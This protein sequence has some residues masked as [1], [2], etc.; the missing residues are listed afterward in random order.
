MKLSIPG[1]FGFMAVAIVAVVLTPALYAVQPAPATQ[2]DG[3]LRGRQ[4]AN[5]RGKDLEGGGSRQN[6][7]RLADAGSV[8]PPPCPPSNHDSGE[9][10]DGVV[11]IEPIPGIDRLCPGS[12][13]SGNSGVRGVKGDTDGA[14]PRTKID[15]D[16]YIRR[17]SIFPVVTKEGIRVRALPETPDKRC[18]IICQGRVNIVSESP[19]FGVIDVEADEVTITR[20]CERKKNTARAADGATWVDDDDLPME[21][22]FKGNV[23]LLH[24]RDGGGGG[25]DER[26][27]IRGAELDYVFVT[28]RLTAIDATVLILRSNVPSTL[29]ASRIELSGFLT[30]QPARSPAPSGDRAPHA[31]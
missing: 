1:G 15:L 20:S 17:T 21:M 23:V 3:E 8:S 5:G 11:Q 13:E 4:E 22:R 29:E 9:P 28:D 14:L 26:R 10:E 30:R 25:I 2:A 16:H 18:T 7:G 27:I 24:A 31:E 12:S 19:T 6:Q